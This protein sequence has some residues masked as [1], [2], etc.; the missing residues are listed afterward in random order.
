MGLARVLYRGV[1]MDPVRV[2]SGAE[3]DMLERKIHD[4][5]GGLQDR[6]A[7]EH[8][9]ADLAGLWVAVRAVR[10]VSSLGP[11]QRRGAIGGEIE[12][13]LNILDRPAKVEVIRSGRTE[14]WK[15]SVLGSWRDE[16]NSQRGRLEGRLVTVEKM[17]QSVR[18]A[19]TAM[20]VELRHGLSVV[21]EEPH[22]WQLARE[23]IARRGV[24]EEDKLNFPRLLQ[25]GQLRVETIRRVQAPEGTAGLFQVEDVKG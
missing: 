3:R 15:G 16:Y 7:I 25:D 6:D 23:I 17:H 9:P 21:R 13:V 22:I 4:Q 14:T 12:K 19:A 5:R 2:L 20:A 11:E 10:M 24:S 8:V 1:A 18:L